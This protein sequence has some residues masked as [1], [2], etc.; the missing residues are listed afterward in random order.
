M[1]RSLGLLAVVL[2]AV[3][4][5]LLVPYVIPLGGPE[6][7]H[8]A[9]LV[10]P[11]GAFVQ[12]AGESLYYTYYPGSGQTVLLIHGFGGSTITWVDT[13]P[14]LAAAGYEVYAVDLLGFGLSGK[15]WDYDYSHPAQAARVVGL[16]DA[17]GI[18]RATVVGHS[19]GGNVAA[20]L[21][22]SYPARVERLALV[23]A[24]V[25]EREGSGGGFLPV[26]VELFDFPVARQWGRLLIR[27]LVA[28]MFDDL[29]FDAAYQDGMIRA[30]IAQGYR[31]VLHTPNWDLSLMGITRDGGE[32]ALPAPVSELQVPVL[33]LWGAEDTWVP[34]SDGEQL[35][36][37]IPAAQR[38]TLD[39][40]GHLPMHEAPERFNAALLA[41]LQGE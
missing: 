10:D 17:L 31:R 7:Q 21:A 29:L 22:L 12:V 24:A 15:Q 2:L 8:P 13:A 32:N 20:H 36:R 9:E 6:A 4:G 35:E 26:P 1:N 23:S 16:M 34:A 30:E 11:N 40:I 33:L 5:L 39:E 28:P 27:E 18:E 25:L 38:V 19:M 3:T 37:L 14:V 41:F